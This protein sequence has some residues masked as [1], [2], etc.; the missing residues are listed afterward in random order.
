M[1]VA[2]AVASELAPRHRARTQFSITSPG[3]VLNATDY[4]TASSLILVN[5]SSYDGI[6][7]YSGQ[8]FTLLYDQ[9]C[10]VGKFAFAS[11]SA[12]FDTPNLVKMLCDGVAGIGIQG[13]M[14]TVGQSRC[15]TFLPPNSTIGKFKAGPTAKAACAKLSK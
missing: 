2:V 3:T 12:N 9:P 5:A 10:A 7:Y 14:M 6:D 13:Q 11:A 8:P 1:S 4:L 15:G